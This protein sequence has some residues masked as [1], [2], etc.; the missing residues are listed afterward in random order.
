MY[1]SSTFYT[2]HRIRRDGEIDRVKKK[3]CFVQFVFLKSRRVNEMGSVVK[4]FLLCTGT[5]IRGKKFLIEGINNR[6]HESTL[7]SSLVAAISCARIARRRSQ[8]YP[9]AAGIQR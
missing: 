8:F 6:L 4:I 9:P 3:K 5:C 2:N 7:L 1:A